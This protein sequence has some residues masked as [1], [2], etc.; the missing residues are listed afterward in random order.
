MCTHVLREELHERLA[1]ETKRELEL[2]LSKEIYLL[3]DLESLRNESEKLPVS[4]HP[5]NKIEYMGSD[6]D[7]PYITVEAHESIG[8][9]A[10]AMSWRDAP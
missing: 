6:D 3:F 1:S 9:R 10:V 4:L 7:T 2:E 8:K 5:L